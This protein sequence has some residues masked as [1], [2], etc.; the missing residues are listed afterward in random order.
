VWYS[1]VDNHD[2]EDIVDSHL[3]KGI[4]VERLRLPESIGR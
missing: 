4:V 2:I 1:F 3:K